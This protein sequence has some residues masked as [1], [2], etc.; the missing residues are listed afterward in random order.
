MISLNYIRQFHRDVQIP[1][2]KIPLIAII[3]FSCYFLH[4]HPRLIRNSS[5]G[6][7]GIR[8]GNVDAFSMVT[9]ITGLRHVYWTLLSLGRIKNDK[10]CLRYGTSRN[11][12][13]FL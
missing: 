5:C 11:G 6:I 8:V 13:A 1:S 7:K 4:I 2:S 10:V 9:P 12:I 3:P